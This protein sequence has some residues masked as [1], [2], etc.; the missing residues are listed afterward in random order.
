MLFYP[1]L[2]NK[3]MKINIFRTKH[4]NI[5]KFSHLNNLK[6]Y[7]HCYLQVLYSSNRH[8]V[9]DIR[10]LNMLCRK[11]FSFFLPNTYRIH[12]V[13]QLILFFMPKTFISISFSNETIENKTI[14]RQHIRSRF[15]KMT[16]PK[17]VDS[18][19]TIFTY[20]NTNLN[21]IVQFFLF[22]APKDDLF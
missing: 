21:L 16:A 1:K 11:Y 15:I 6:I 20:L 10:L 18:N 2:G 3:N 19:C 8:G 7:T 17:L 4:W 12:T 22:T 14:S 9:I 5:V 13:Q